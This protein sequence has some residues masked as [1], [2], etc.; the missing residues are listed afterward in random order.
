MGLVLV[1]GPS[2]AEDERTLAAQGGRMGLVLVVGPS[3]ADSP[4]PRSPETAAAK[5]SSWD[6]P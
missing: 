2:G 6:R 4:I 1:V 5:S 3:G